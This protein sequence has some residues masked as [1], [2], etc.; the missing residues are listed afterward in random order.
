M[1]EVIVVVYY[2]G[3]VVSISEGVLF[4]CP[5]G[6]KFIKI[7]EEMSFVAL[8]KAVMDIV[9]GDSCV[10]YDCM[11]LKDDNKFSSKGSIEL[12]AMVDQSL[13]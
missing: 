11:K 1:E 7:S 12:Y 8:R 3:D 6:S 2:D 4:E 10:E 13:E 5:N 9:R